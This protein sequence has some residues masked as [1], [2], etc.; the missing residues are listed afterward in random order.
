MST[1]DRRRRPATRRPDRRQAPRPP[2]LRPLFAALKGLLARHAR[3]LLVVHDAPDEYFLNT[4]KRTADGKPMFFG[5]VELTR[6][7]VVYR[8]MPLQLDP[9][10]AAA[11]SPALRKQMR[12]NSAF[13]LT[14]VDP[15]A[16]EELDR[17][18]RAAMA[19]FER[20]GLA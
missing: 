18:T 1:T 15:P 17:L 10:L 9:A 20:K 6:S 11:L 13:N 16:L 14:E 5:A 8:L 2:D 3:H 4:R 7:H 12:G 19:S